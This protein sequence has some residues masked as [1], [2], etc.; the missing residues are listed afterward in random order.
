MKL[1]IFFFFIDFQCKLNQIPPISIC[2]PFLNYNQHFTEG[3][4]G[5]SVAIQRADSQPDGIC[6]WPHDTLLHRRL[7]LSVQQEKTWSHPIISEE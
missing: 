1:V 5:A 6:T 7:K 4:H 2:S 3:I